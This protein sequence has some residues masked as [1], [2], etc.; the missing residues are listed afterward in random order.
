MRRSH[1]APPVG[2]LFIDRQQATCSALVGARLGCHRFWGGHKGRPY[3]K[4][5]PYEP[6][7]PKRKSEQFLHT[8]PLI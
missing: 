7:K 3:V 4:L 2:D 1:R 8:R 5:H 6:T